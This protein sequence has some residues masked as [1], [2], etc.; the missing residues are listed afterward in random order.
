MHHSLPQFV[1]YCF[2]HVALPGPLGLL[3]YSDDVL[4]CVSCFFCDLTVHS[5]L[6]ALRRLLLDPTDP[7]QCGTSIDHHHHTA[8][9][10]WM[11]KFGR[12]ACGDWG[13]GLGSSR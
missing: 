13:M 5:L 7:C 12:T 6:R 8:V 9:S 10:S 2:E 3:G 11:R 4:L 1:R